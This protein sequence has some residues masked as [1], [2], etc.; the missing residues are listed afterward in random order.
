MGNRINKIDISKWNVTI[1]SDSLL[2][3]NTFAT[4]F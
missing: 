1:D 3:K 4:V 2:K